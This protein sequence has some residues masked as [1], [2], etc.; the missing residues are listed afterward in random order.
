MTATDTFALDGLVHHNGDRMTPWDARRMAADILAAATLAD[1]IDCANAWH[2]S[3]PHR[4]GQPCPEC[5]PAGAAPVAHVELLVVAEYGV[6]LW[7]GQWM[8][9]DKM[10]D[11]SVRLQGPKAIR[12]N[13]ASAETFVVK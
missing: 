5:R 13:N 2:N 7:Y 3:A 11:G 9:A 10:T 8:A 6:V 12:V 1:G 4:A